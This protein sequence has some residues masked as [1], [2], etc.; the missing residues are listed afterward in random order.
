METKICTKCGREL[1][2]DQF[3]FRN[4]TLGT[5]RA[6]CRDCHNG[7]VKQKYQERKT[8][9]TNLKAQI[10]CAKCGESRGYCLDYHHI[11]PTTKK[12]TIAKFISNST[13]LEGLTEEIEKC[14]VL[15]ANCH[16]EYH[17]LSERDKTLN[18]QKYIAE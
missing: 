6:D 11:D 9:I 3:N 18:I 2:I 8:M 4:K 7:Y 13:S 14:I 16:R 12:F 17:Y 1:P 10:K 5:R 15:C